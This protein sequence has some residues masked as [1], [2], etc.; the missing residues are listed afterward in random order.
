MEKRLLEKLSKLFKTLGLKAP[1][2]G[3]NE[4]PRNESGQKWEKR[5]VKELK[6]MV[7]HQELG[8]G[9]VEDVAVY[10]TGKESHLA[11]NGTETMAYTFAIR[12]DGQIV[13]CNSF[14]RATWSQGDKARKGDENKEFLAVMFEGKFKTVGVSDPEAGQPN[15]LQLL[16][17]LML[18]Q[19]CKLEWN[20]SETDLYGHYQF[21][22]RSCPGILLQSIVEGIRFN[23]PK[24]K[25]NFDLI[26]DRQKALKEL[27]FYKSNVDGIWGNQSKMALLEF[28]KQN[29][30]TVDGLWGPETEHQASILAS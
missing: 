9:S 13:L 3:R 19:T 21:G 5:S 25:W 14:N 17:A 10:H 1:F 23:A 16:S 30:L 8:W 4:L 28:Q 22:K 20:W 12:R 24:G 11:E 26:H 2:D 27:G 7:W 15:D 29:N 6:G 18:W